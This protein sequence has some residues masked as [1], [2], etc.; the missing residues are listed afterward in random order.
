MRVPILS[1]VVSALASLALAQGEAQQAPSV[2]G[3]DGSIDQE[4]VSF[5][6]EQGLQKSEVMEHL[7][8]LCDVYGPRL[9]S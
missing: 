4:A 7:S 6:L 1:A 3:A 2:P 8:W 5:F 9:G